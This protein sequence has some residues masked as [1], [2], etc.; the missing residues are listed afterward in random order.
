M[1][2]S[3]Q[4][5]NG[6]YTRYSVILTIE[7]LSHGSSMKQRAGEDPG[8]GP[9]SDGAEDGSRAVIA[10][11]ARVLRTLEQAPHGL[12]IAQITRASALPRTTV[13]RLVNSLQAEQLVTL[14]G[15]QVGLGPALARLAAAASQDVRTRVRPHLERLSQETGESVDLWVLQNDVVVLV[16]EVV[17]AQEV[18]I[19][20]PIGSAFP[21]TCTAPGKALLA[22]WTDAEIAAL[23]ARALPGPTAQSLG[24]LAA[25]MADIGEIRQTGVA[26]DNEEHADD[27]CALGCA[28]HLGTAERHAIAIPAPARRFRAQRASLE[29]ALRH[30]AAALAQ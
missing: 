5:F 22:E 18:R 1:V 9:A 21:L 15:S 7:W 28:I 26:V 13:Q 23:A 10:R 3:S 19:V 24:S 11:A 14:R 16:D 30:C 20:L 2:D 8:T 6:Q 4:F 12:T 27:I 29:A 25:L 17:A